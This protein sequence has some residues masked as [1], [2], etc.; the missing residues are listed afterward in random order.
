MSSDLLSKAEM[1]EI[2]VMQRLYLYNRGL[3]CGPLAIR[4]ELM[5]INVCPLPS[6]G[7]IKRIL[8]RQGLTYRRTGHYP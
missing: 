7:T 5:L 6:L 1:E 8:N 4:H 3:P 2:V